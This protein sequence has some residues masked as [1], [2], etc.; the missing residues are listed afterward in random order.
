MFRHMSV[1]PHARSSHPTTCMFAQ[2]YG[3]AHACSAA[4]AFSCMHVGLQPAGSD[5][6]MQGQLTACMISCM[7]GRP[8][9][10]S[11]ACTFGCM[12]HVF[13]HSHAANVHASDRGN[14]DTPDHA[15]SQ[16]CMCTFCT[17]CMRVQPHARSGA[18]TFSRVF[19]FCRAYHDRVR[20]TGLAN[21][22]RSETT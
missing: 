10:C 16:M 20:L 6:C 18:G 2:M 19:F 22:E 4:C 15:C 21:G 12:Q 8:H 1:L 9:A 11:A 17:F 14:V 7:H 3:R 5:R 13:E